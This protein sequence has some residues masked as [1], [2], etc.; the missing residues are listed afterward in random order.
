MTVSLISLSTEDDVRILKEKAM[1]RRL[2]AMAQSIVSR[3]QLGEESPAEILA[4]AE[5]GIL[6][7]VLTRSTAFSA[8]VYLLHAGS[9]I[10]TF[11]FPNGRISVTWPVWNSTICSPRRPEPVET[12]IIPSPSGDQQGSVLSSEPLVSF[13]NFLFATADSGEENSLSVA[14]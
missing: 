4:G 5:D 10:S 6:R 2:M 11:L 9:R 14:M 7:K 12:N 8:P 13:V 1:L 3:C